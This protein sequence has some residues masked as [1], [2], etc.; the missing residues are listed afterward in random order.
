LGRQWGEWK[1]IVAKNDQADNAE[2]APAFAVD[3]LADK[4][5]R[6]GCGAVLASLIVVAVVM[7]G[8]LE[9]IPALATVSVVFIG[10]AGV[11]SVTHGE[12][13]IRGL[14]K[15]VKWLA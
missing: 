14:L 11:F 15:V 2:R 10:G 13:S 8:L 9:G 5:I 3:T 4:A 1:S 12:R 7:F 6:F